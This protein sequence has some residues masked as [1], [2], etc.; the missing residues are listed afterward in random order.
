LQTL[1]AAKQGL[2]YLQIFQANYARKYIFWIIG[3][4]A[5]TVRQFVVAARSM[6]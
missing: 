2:D 1:A 5:Y 3:R 4:T 6:A